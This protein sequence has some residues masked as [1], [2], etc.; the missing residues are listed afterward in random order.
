MCIAGVLLLCPL[1]SVA[2]FRPHSG[3]YR[4][5]SV[6]VG[7]GWN[8]ELDAFTV[9]KK[10]HFQ[11]TCTTTITPPTARASAPAGGGGTGI[12]GS[13]EHLQYAVQTHDGFRKF[14]PAVDLFLEMHGIK[15]EAPDYHV[16]LTHSLV[17]RTKA[18]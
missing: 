11:I 5:C 14:N 4:R 8:D 10:N 17:D 15:I 18:P 13:S 3:V 1:P 7:F 2:L 6:A 16:R 9:Q 12:T